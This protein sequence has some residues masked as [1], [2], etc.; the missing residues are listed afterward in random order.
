MF[1]IIIK[2]S[3]FLFAVKSGKETDEPVDFSD[4]YQEFDRLRSKHQIGKWA[5][6]KVERNY[7]FEIPGVPAQS[8]YLKAVYSFEG[9]SPS[10]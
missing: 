2:P 9:N 1:F 3:Y 8:E 10:M 7:A 5:A 6:K 4:V